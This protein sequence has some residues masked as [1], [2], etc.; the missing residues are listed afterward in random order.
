MYTTFNY[1]TKKALRED[2]AKRQTLCED[3]LWSLQHL[4][5]SNF[6]EVEQVRLDALTA[7][8]AVYSPGL[9]PAPVNGS[10]TIEGPHYPAPHRWY[11]TAMVEDGII[12]S[13]R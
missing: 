1:K 8:L 3:K 7:K 12:T 2:V 4:D 10:C 9:F 11:A 13:A 6:G 5:H